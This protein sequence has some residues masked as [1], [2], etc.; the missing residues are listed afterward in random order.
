MHCWGTLRLAI[1]GGTDVPAETKKKDKHQP[2][3]GFLEDPTGV[4][5]MNLLLGDVLQHVVVYKEYF[6]PN[7]HITAW[8]TTV[9]VARCGATGGQRASVQLR[10]KAAR[11]F[12]C[13]LAQL[14]L[15][16]NLEFC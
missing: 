11:T 2:V 3:D 7:Q 14:V 9:F 15:Q 10:T 4:V 13:A 6:L 5:L 1:S 8:K 12:P 16:L